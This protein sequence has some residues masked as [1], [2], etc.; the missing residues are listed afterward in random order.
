MV[1]TSASNIITIIASLPLVFGAAQG[2]HGPGS[3]FGDSSVDVKHSLDLLPMN[4]SIGLTW[5]VLQV[6]Q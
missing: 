3:Q 1:T 4:L 6:E 5:R 2:S